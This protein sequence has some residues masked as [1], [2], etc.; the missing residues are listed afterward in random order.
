MDRR[1]V[2][3][4]LVSTSALRWAWSAITGALN[5]L[6]L[7]GVAGLVA[8]G[9]V[10]PSWAGVGYVAVALLASLVVGAY[11]VW[12]RTDLERQQA[13]K[14]LGDEGLVPW[15]A[16][17]ETEVRG[18]QA[19]LAEQLA[20]PGMDGRR[21]D[22]IELIQATFWQVNQDVLRRLQGEARGWVEYYSQNPPWFYAGLTRITHEQLQEVVRLLACTADQLAHVQAGIS[23]GIEAPPT[24][25]AA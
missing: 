5:I 4:R 12:D 9:W 11:R 24:R 21:F 22:R 3:L 17:R 1:L 20:E 19:D 7:L 16:A 6:A 15:L 14:A 25:N 13:E 10:P 2:F 23:Q 18:L 8:V